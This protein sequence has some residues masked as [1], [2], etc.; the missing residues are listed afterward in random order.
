VH[1]LR[2]VDLVLVLVAGRVRALHLAQLALE[3]GVHHPVRL[4]GGELA[5][6]AVVLLVDEVEESREAVAVLEAHAAAVAH[7]EDP[8]D[9]L[10][11]ARGVQ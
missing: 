10:L 11:Q 6:V 8:R 2:E 9:L 1:E 4:R 7:L 3:A 5:D